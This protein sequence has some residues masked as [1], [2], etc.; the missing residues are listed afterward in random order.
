MLL[1]VDGAVHTSFIL[2]KATICIA[3][4]T[5]EWTSFYKC[6]YHLTK[7]SPAYYSFLIVDTNAQL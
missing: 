2:T 1:V 3:V 5:Q 4:I 6:N 7:M